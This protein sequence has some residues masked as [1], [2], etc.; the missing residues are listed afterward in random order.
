MKRLLATLQKTPFKQSYAPH[1]PDTPILALKNINM[2]F[3]G[4]NTLENISFDLATGE[5]VAVAGPNGAGKSTL[6]KIIAGV[7]KATSGSVQIYGHEP[8][9]HI[10]IS[11]IPQ[12]SQIDWSFPVTIADV[13]MMGRVGK[14]KTFEWPKP[15]DWQKVRQA[16]ETV[17]LLELSKRQISELSGGQQQRMFIARAL[18]QE[19]ELMLMDEP[20]TGLDITAQ[21]QIFQVLTTLKKEK[22]TLL[23]SMHDLKLAAEH[24]DRIMLLNK[25]KI[26]FGPPKQVFTT[27]LLTSAYGGHLHILDGDMD[28]LA[29]SDTCC[30]GNLHALD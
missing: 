5:Q 14:L 3:K 12:R 11:Y 28:T 25:K 4:T 23:V 10:C 16:L 9:G 21:E 29:I 18:A 17:G 20:F 26:G 24:F 8:G 15:S 22:V 30:E 7:W 2:R 6:F 27:E 19:A 13:V 1:H